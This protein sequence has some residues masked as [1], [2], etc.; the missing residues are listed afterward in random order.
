MSLQYSINKW[1]KIWTI[2]LYCHYY[3]CM[4]LEFLRLV[5]HNNI[6]RNKTNLVKINLSQ[7][8]YV[9]FKSMPF[10]WVQNY[11]SWN[12]EFMKLKSWVH[13]VEIVNS[14]SWNREFMKL[15]C[16]HRSFVENSLMHFHIIIFT[17]SISDAPLMNI[18]NYFDEV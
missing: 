6:L 11:K 10:L 16:P 14:W 2:Y 3:K 12:R 1:K 5:I 8:S 4:L 13:E 15:K 18:K 17:N 9:L 7:P